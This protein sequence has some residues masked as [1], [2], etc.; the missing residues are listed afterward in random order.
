MSGY[1]GEEYLEAKRWVAEKRQ[2]G[3][4]WEEIVHLCVDSAHEYN[5]FDKLQNDE[6][7]IPEMM[8]FNEWEPF[9]EAMKNSY[10][11]IGPIP[12]FDDGNIHNLP[13][14][15][16]MESAWVNYKNYLLGKGSGEAKM[17]D[18]AVS[19]IENNCYWMLN[20]LERDTRS[21][22]S[23]KGLVMGSVQSGKTSNM[24]GLVT[25]AAHYDWNIFIILSGT[26]DNLRKQTR[27]RFLEDLS[28]S[29]GLSWHVMDHTSKAEYMVDIKSG[30]RYSS[31]NLHLNSFQDGYSSNEWFHRYVF[32]CL[33]NSKRLTNLINWLH[34]KPERA[35]KM[36]IVV[37]DD[38]ADQ[39]SVNT[40]KMGDIEDEE[41]IERTK[42]NQLIINLVKGYD[43][44][45]N[46]C[47]TN[48]QAMNYICFTA[49]PYANVLNEAYRDSL[50]PSSFICNLPESNEYFGP[51]EIW[52]SKKDDRYSGLNIL[53][54]IPDTEMKDLKSLHNGQAFT[55]PEEFQKSVAWFLCA[56]AI[57]RNRGHKKPIS[58]LIH[59]TN[60]QRGHFEE[61]DVLKS[62]LKRE[63]ETGKLLTLC[64]R[65]Y[66]EERDE[67]R[68]EDLAEGYPDYSR[69]DEVNND[70]PTFSEIEPDICN[71]LKEIVNI[72]LGSDKQL[73]YHE[74]GLH[75]C[76]DNCSANRIAEEG[77]YL[78]VVYPS[79]IELRNMKKAPVFI[80][81][82]GNTL[83]RG[84][85]LEGLVCTYFA[86][87]VNQADTLMQMA[88]WFGYRKGYELLQRIWMSKQIQ[89][90][91]ELIEEI[92]ENLKDEFVD[93]MEKG[94]SPSMFGPRVMSSSK[95]ARF[96]LTS[97]NKSQNMVACD[98]DF[99]GDSYE[100]TQFENSNDGLKHNIDITEKFLSQVG[101]PRASDAI[102]A[103]YVWDGV[104]SAVVLSE[105]INKYK[106]FDCSSLH[107]DI[108]IFV[109]WISKMNADNKFLKWNIAIAGDNSSDER[110]SVAGVDVGKI[111]RSRK[112]K[113]DNIDIGS[114]RSGR[115]I[116]SDIIVADL[117]PEK[118]DMFEAAKKS[119]K[120]L[121]GLRYELGYE[122]SPLLLLYRIDKDK[123]TESKLRTVI[124]TDQDIIGFSIVIAGQ[125][126]NSDYIK[127]VQV[128]I[129]E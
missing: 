127:T 13:L 76:V 104:D 62:W 92:D 118:R 27:D 49:T 73:I 59:T 88:R 52:G 28:H 70:F 60:L 78:R 21:I 102:E 122:D 50:Y 32:V 129:P 87:N 108:P 61:Y 94:K 125:K 45:G 31:D 101:A 99:S 109:E 25:M 111:T 15:T 67:F 20:H 54:T 23:V 53:R 30:E 1:A 64:K 75:L 65:I 114:L 24:I 77:T 14:P 38:E 57:L 79:N 8:E 55:L 80:V 43:S 93:F 58:M 113:S 128:K 12:G 34:S 86:R 16:G 85:T 33:K 81:M 42:V 35:A 40:T 56:A 71:M 69:L 11:P 117:S 2:D 3:F 6:L 39:A 5:E 48:F 18:E 51:K 47:S 46:P 110:W 44:E 9:V 66:N 29:V 119:G 103:A 17:S 22:D 124:G 4:E 126:T 106:I 72:E 84:L 100:V 36:R 83:S 7:I 121:I 41:E 89:N 107:N 90:K 10:I 105:F 97:K 26:I 116:L 74:E 19:K 96:L 112:K 98:V 68:I 115:D 82:G 123:G 120:N 91:F 95:I 63:F 37:I